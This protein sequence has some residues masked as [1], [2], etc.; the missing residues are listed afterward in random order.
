MDSSEEKHDQRQRRRT[1]APIRDLT[2]QRFGRLTVIRDSGERRDGAVIWRVRCD[3][4]NESKALGYALTRGSTKSCGCLGARGAEKGRSTAGTTFTSSKKQ[5]VTDGSRAFQ[6]LFA[7]YRC[8]AGKRGIQFNLQ[9]GEFKVLVTSSCTYCGT[10]PAQKKEWRGDTFVYNGVD[11]IDSGGPYAL[12]NCVS[13][14]GPCNRAKG[15]MTVEEFKA[16]IRR[17]Y[18]HMESSPK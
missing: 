13:C 17:V 12:S 9:Q 5:I 14:C 7:T 18:L 2:G 8:M 15:E 4:G 3:C 1:G 16:F 6:H 11:R 10:L